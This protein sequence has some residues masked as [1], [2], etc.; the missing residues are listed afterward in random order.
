MDNSYLE[1]KF[2]DSG[3]CLLRKLFQLFFH[4]IR[5]PKNAVAI[6]SRVL[7]VY[8]RSI[9]QVIFVFKLLVIIGVTV[10]L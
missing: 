8:C 7:Q 1:I 10:Y 2:R 4:F 3:Y 5:L 9:L 6:E